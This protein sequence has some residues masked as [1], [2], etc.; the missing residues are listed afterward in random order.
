MRSRF[1]L[2]LFALATSAI[3]GP[4]VA[5]APDAARPAEDIARDAARKPAEMVAF[6]GIKPGSRIVDFI[7]GGGYFTRVFAQAAGP[8]GTV[9]A[10]VP[11]GAAKLDPASARAMEALAADKRFG[12][13]TVV[14]DIGAVGAPGTFDVI[15]TAQNY[16]DLYNFLPPEGIADFNKGMFAMLKPGGVFVVID[17]AA[18]AG[19]GVS[20]TKTLHRIDPARVKADVVAAGFVFDGETA[21]LSNP[22]DDRSKLV[23]D[24]AV[25]GKTDQFAYRFRKP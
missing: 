16:H 4:A 24:P 15:W 14:P 5:Q 25:R 17:H 3:M 9:V 10:I 21:V 2:V 6:A 12:N 20:A 7:A 11:P 8:G 18:T 13:I 23:F 1:G 22:A 19:S